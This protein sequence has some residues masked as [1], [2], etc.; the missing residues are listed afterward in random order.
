M[1]SLQD[2]QT[3]LEAALARLERSLDR[4]P[5]PGAGD[6]RELERALAKARADYT[7][8][9]ARSDSVAD[10]LDETIARL[11]RLLGVAAE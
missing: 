8:L 7:D 5:V 4:A 10:R 11:R 3:R 9:K 6:V 1:T 2:A